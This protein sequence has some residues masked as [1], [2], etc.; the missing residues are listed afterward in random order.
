MEFGL[1]VMVVN[2]HV[3]VHFPFFKTQQEWLKCCKYSSNGVQTA[4]RRS[5]GETGCQVSLN[6][7]QAASRCTL[8]NAL[9]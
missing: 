6:I 1:D 2:G 8:C 3:Q 5:V 4:A 9:L 7:C